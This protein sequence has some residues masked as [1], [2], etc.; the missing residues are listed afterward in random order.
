MGGRRVVYT[1]LY[2]GYERLR[3][4]PVSGESSIEF[5]CFTDDPDA[6]SDT[7]QIRH[8]PPPFPADQNRSSRR[9]KI[10][11]HEYLA[12]FDESLYIDNSVLLTAAPERIFAEW[13]PEGVPMALL[14]HSFRGPVREEFEAV[15]ASGLDADWLCDEQLE[16]YEKHVPSALAAVTT[17]N[18]ILLRRHHD[19]LVRETM[20]VWWEHVL[21]YSRRDQLS[22]AVAL[23]A[24]G[25]VPLTHAIDNH[26]S[27][28]HVWPRQ[29][30]ERD[31]AGGAP[32]PTGPRRVIAGLEQQVA[33]LE[34]Q[35]AGLVA[36][37]AAARDENAVLA[38]QAHRGRV[39]QHELV[40][41]IDELRS[42]TS[43]RATRP[44]RAASD[45]IRRLRAARRSGAPTPR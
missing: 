15:V 8:A 36:E 45:A 14:A 24:T 31:P 17:W 13:L 39:A 44:L 2:G 22:L 10:L 41:E 28:Y 23:Q 9:P 35:V 29:D 34:Q 4:Q 6:T 11:A 42:S 19:L 12:D 7:W 16:H 40:R 27:E 1:C 30:R 37:C 5:V 32:L 20:R 18:G 26:R 25:L 21:R 38:D 43:W 33:A 3:D